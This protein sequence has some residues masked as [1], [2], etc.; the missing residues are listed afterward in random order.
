[1]ISKLI[2]LTF[3]GC[4]S[5]QKMNRSVSARPGRANFWPRWPGGGSASGA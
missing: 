1:V 2:T 5:R 4:P 3:W